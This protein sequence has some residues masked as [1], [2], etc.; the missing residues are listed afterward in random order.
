[1][2]SASL[3]MCRTV[4]VQGA[5]SLRKERHVSK[6]LSWSCRQ[7]QNTIPFVVALARYICCWQSKR[8]PHAKK[9]ATWWQESAMFTEHIG[10]WYLDTLLVSVA[11]TKYIS[12]LP[13]KWSLISR[14]F[15]LAMV[16][17]YAAYHPTIVKVEM[18]CKHFIDRYCM[19]ALGGVIQTS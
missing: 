10:W 19:Y 4:T 6:P 12:Y 14:P 7:C 5:A 8:S 2:A 9:T 1:M 16:F 13:L 15:R 11:L 18:E 3:A 17:G